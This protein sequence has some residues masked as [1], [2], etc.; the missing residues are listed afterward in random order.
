[1]K[2]AQRVAKAGFNLV[3]PGCGLAARVPLAN[4]HGMV[5]GVKG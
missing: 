1:M 3:A 4:I 5:K 2:E